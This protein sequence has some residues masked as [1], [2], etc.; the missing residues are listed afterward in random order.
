MKRIISVVLAVVMVLST[1]LM[2][3]CESSKTPIVDNTP[4]NDPDAF[5]PNSVI[6]NTG[7]DTGIKLMI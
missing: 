5:D 2:V 4:V 3:G 6:V 1:C 7:A